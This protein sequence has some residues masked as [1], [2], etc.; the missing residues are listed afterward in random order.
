MALSEFV[1]WPSDK[2]DQKFK[3]FSFLNCS[4]AMIFIDEFPRKSIIK[5]TLTLAPH[6]I[7]PLVKRQL[8]PTDGKIKLNIWV[9]LA[10]I[11]PKEWTKFQHCSLLSFHLLLP[12][13]LR[14]ASTSQCTVRKS[15]LFTHV[16]SSPLGSSARKKWLFSARVVA[17]VS[18]Y[19]CSWNSA[20]WL[21]ISLSTIFNMPKA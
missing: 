3:S 13:C 14:Y 7:G 2:P 1:L 20:L 18:R 5:N 8:R 17:L 11:W 10:K 12:R 16:R 6:P 19:L 9:L 4:P 21:V 15:N